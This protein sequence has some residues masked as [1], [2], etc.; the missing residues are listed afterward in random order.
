MEN[1]LFK[2]GVLLFA[3]GSMSC[4]SLWA[5]GTVEDYNRA[6]ALREKYNAKHVLYAGVVPHWVDQTSAFWYVRQTEKGKEYVK[7]D[8]ASKKRTA[9]FDQQKMASALTEKAGR[10]INAYNLPLQNCRLNISLDTLRFQLDGKFWAYSIKNNRLLDEG[11]IPSRG[12]ERHWMEVDDEKEGS[13]VTSPDGK[14]TAFIKNDNVYVREVA[15]GKEKQLSQDGTLSNYYSSYIQWSPDSKSVVSCRI[16]PVEKR[17]VYYVESS[18]ADQAQPKLHKQEYAKPG[19]ELRFKVP[20]IFEVESGRR[21][22][23]STE[24]FSHQYELSGPMW[25]ADSKAI[26]FEY[27]ERGH[28]V[29]RVLEMSAVDGSVRTLIE[30]KEEKYVNYPRIY[31]NYLSDGKRIIWLSERD[32]YNHLYLYD[33]ATGKPLNQ[34]TKGEWYVR[35]VQHVDEANE[36]IYFSA[37]GMKKGEDP[38][39]IHYYKINFD[40]SNLVE[41]T[42]EEGMHQCWYSS[43][44]KYLV[45]VYSKVD[46]APIAVLRD[47]KNGKIRMQLDKADISALLANGWKAP[48]VF[49]AKGRDGKTDMWGVIY[50]PSNFDPSKKYPVIEYIYSGPGDQ[51]VP[52][53]FSS[54]NWWMTSLAELGF[55]VV[56][57]DGMTTS[58][59]SKEF[60]EVCYKNLKDAGLPDHIAWIKAAAQKYPYMDID[61]VGIFGCSAGGQESTGAVLFHPEFYKA[62]YSACGCHDNRMDKIWWNELWMGYPVDESYSACSN[63]DNAHLL[64]RPLMLVVGEL[65]DNVDPASTMQ[66]A[67]ALIK[68]NKDFELVVIPGAHHTMGEDFGEHKRYDFFVRHL[69]GV[70]PP[71]WDK[72]KTGK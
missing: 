41:L 35:G 64:S 7:V 55:I 42:P 58:F 57:V 72:V 24:L 34:I 21:L 11:A 6:Y 67:N 39:L 3:L 33:R 28:K 8:A 63:V 59:R 1:N 19:D 14:W 32:N 36:V 49:S 62:A 40:G 69:M 48:E 16:R 68:A 53:T 71:S 50:R 23:P 2:S 15:T 12:K 22:I 38:Y 44:Y 10:E 37:N 47:A 52:K 31:R 30:E 27:N 45:D 9:L 4:I 66:V 18:P 70:T 54:Y 61:R 20:C 29:Y 51:Y 25:N 60:E 26:T 5:Q 65:D 43:D 56:Q 17:Y 46:Q 13:P